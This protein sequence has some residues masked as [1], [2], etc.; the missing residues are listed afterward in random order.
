[1]KK[2]ICIILAVLIG[3]STLVEKMPAVTVKAAHSNISSFQKNVA[4]IARND[5]LYLA[6]M[7]NE[8]H[9]SVKEIYDKDKDWALSWLVYDSVLMNVGDTVE[10]CWL[11]AKGIDA[12]HNYTYK[13]ESSDNSVAIVDYNGKITALADGTATITFSYNSKPRLI[14][15]TYAESTSVIVKVGKE[16]WGLC[17]GDCSLI[18]MDKVTVGVNGSVI[19]DLGLGDDF[20]YEVEMKS[21]NPSVIYGMKS[22]QDQPAMILGKRSGAAEVTIS[23]SNSITGFFYDQKINVNVIEET[24]SSEWDDP[25]YKQYGEDYINMFRNVSPSVTASSVEHIMYYPLAELFS[26]KF[27]KIDASAL[28]ELA[29]NGLKIGIF[30]II[31]GKNSYKNKL[32]ED[33]II[34]FLEELKLSDKNSKYFEAAE[35]ELKK[36]KET[37]ENLKKVK[38]L[39]STLTSLSENELKKLDSTIETL[40]KEELIL[41]DKDNGSLYEFLSGDMLDIVCE[42][43]SDVTEAAEYLTTIVYLVELEEDYL[44]MLQAMSSPGEALY[45]DIQRLKETIH[46]DPVKYFK[47]AYGGDRLVDCVKKTLDTAAGMGKETA[48]VKEFIKMLADMNGVPSLKE[49]YKAT[50]LLEYRASVC[51]HMS[52]IET[53]LMNSSHTYTAEEIR[54]LIDEYEY[55]CCIWL[56]L[57]EPLQ[58]TIRGLYDYEDKLYP[59]LWRISPVAYTAHYDYG[60]YIG[61]AMQTYYKMDNKKSFV[62]S[63]PLKLGPDKQLTSDTFVMGVGESLALRFYGAA[64]YDREKDGVSKEWISSDTSVVTVDNGTVKAIAP[65]QAEII[66]KVNVSKTDTSYMGKTIITV[67]ESDVSEENTDPQKNENASETTAIVTEAT[68]IINEDIVTQ[69]IMELAKHLKINNGTLDEGKGRYF[70]VNEHSCDKN[71]C[72]DYECKNCYNANVL[73]SQWFR[74]EFGYNVDVKLLPRQYKGEDKVGGYAGYTCYGFANFVGWYIAKTDEN[75]D[76]YRRQLKDSNGIGYKE[77]TINNLKSLDIRIGDIVRI[78]G[79]GHV[80]SFVFLKY[81]DEDTILMLDNNAKECGAY[82]CGIHKYSFTKRFGDNSSGRFDGCYMAVTRMSNYYPDFGKKNPDLVTAN[83]E[84]GNVS[85]PDLRGK[86]LAEAKILLRNVGLSLG[87][88]MPDRH[89]TIPAGSVISQSVQAGTKAT[90]GTAINVSMSMGENW[91]AS[92]T[93]ISPA[94]P[95]PTA[96][97]KPTP[98]PG[99]ESKESK[100]EKPVVTPVP[101]NIKPDQSENRIGNWSEWLTKLPDGVDNESY[102]IETKKQYKETKWVNAISLDGWVRT[103]RTD[104]EQALI[105]EWTN[106]PLVAENTDLYRINIDTK[107]EQQRVGTRYFYYVFF[108]PHTGGGYY[109]TF[110]PD[111]QHKNIAWKY[112]Q[113][114]SDGQICTYTID[115]NDQEYNTNCA[116]I[117][118]SIPWAGPEGYGARKAIGQNVEYYHP[119][120]VYS[121]YARFTDEK[122]YEPIY[123]ECTYYREIR[124]NILY[125]YYRWSDSASG[126]ETRTLVRYR[127]K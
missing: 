2:C 113:E 47:Q 38:K 111:R 115:T 3:I 58:K 104:S 7:Y 67:V 41:N 36:I 65:G 122:K 11:N 5:E 98:I 75:S 125:E 99:N 37:S 26:E 53:E 93:A 59:Y 84:T 22:S 32:N 90:V 118:Q 42:V 120:Y 20:K 106:E 17:I 91:K 97:P 27:K 112:T 107:K 29:T 71:V 12:L 114:Y 52:K 30:E 64:E 16:S 108:M 31:H 73:A 77:F 117:T 4:R 34:Y 61:T 1:M 13:W 55:T 100:E 39:E 48:A 69:R 60:T 46:K 23:I 109:F 95:T 83:E 124:Y 105:G 15:K 72:K 87:S 79:N 78:T 45:D 92:T 18:N 123:A 28:V 35:K 102:E 54:E 25:Y 74:D 119:G 86:T 43:A 110:N 49:E 96:I 57:E 101:S 88:V 85:V 62:Y 103:G 8:N 14:G 82:R 68:D 19:C 33:S 63:A 127:S 89:D 70:T 121:G 94:T 56:A 9:E 81:V 21:S 80:H 44:D 51:S 76:V 126:N 6:Y 66:C 10:L 40:S 116:K 24:N 50:R